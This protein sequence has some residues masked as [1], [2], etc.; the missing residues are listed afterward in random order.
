MLRVLA[1][2]LLVAAPA[3]AQA[4]KPVVSG[5]VGKACDAY[6]SRAAAY[7]FEGVVLVQ[8]G[9]KPLL[10]KGW[11]EARPGVPAGP[12]TLYDLASA[13]KQVTATAILL[14]ESRGELELDDSIAEHLP[15]VPPEHA[16]VTIHHL[17]T[18]TS[19]WPREGPAGSGDDLEAALATYFS[20]ARTA[21][22]GTRFQYYNGGYAMLAGIVERVTGD[23][24][25][26][27]VARELFARAKLVETDFVETARVDHER[28]AASPDGERLV[29]EYIKGWGYRGMGGVLTNVDDVARWVRAVDAGKVLPKSRLKTLFEPALRGYACGWYVIPTS[30]G[31]RCHFHRG[32]AM[33]MAAHVRHFPDEDVILVLFTSTPEFLDPL[34]AA[35]SSL[36]FSEAPPGGEPPKVVD[37]AKKHADAFVGRWEGDAGALTVEARGDGFAVAAAGPRL[38]AEFPRP[39]LPRGARPGWEPTP[40]ELLGTSERA[41]AIVTDVSNGSP[42]SLADALAPGIPGAWPNEVAG[43]YWPAHV[44]EHGGVERL[45]L[46]GAAPG[47]APRTTHVW[48]RLHH[49]KKA[50]AVRLMLTNTRVN[51]FTFDARPDPFV[52]RAAPTSRTRLETFDF[53][54]GPGFVLELKRK[55]AE[56]H[57]TTPSGTR[58]TFRRPDR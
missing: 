17:L 38:A 52:A 47:A 9:K 1:C 7:G 54:D 11:G 51:V 36:A 6:V 20:G 49:E 55:G 27:W 48:V 37:L 53:T 13:S 42:A 4:S 56:L 14:L 5:K 31:R 44:D 26:D 8:K 25:E 2:S 3:L 10:R 41:L 45:E 40:A 28:I 23:P 29:I 46:V 43:R 30:R 12:E 15:G 22:V 58:H 39:P 33:G 24:F 32:D 34:V 16:E 21:E 19:G 50:T 57:V 18:H 35:L